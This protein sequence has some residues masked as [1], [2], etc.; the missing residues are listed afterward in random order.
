MLPQDQRAPLKRCAAPDQALASPNCPPLTHP[1]PSFAPH[2][3]GAL[4]QLTMAQ[5]KPK[6]GKTRYRRTDE[7]LIADLQKRIEELKQRKAAKK[8]KADPAAKEMNAAFRA[9]TKA[10]ENS[11]KS[12]DAELKRALSGAQRILA[13]YYESKGISVPKARKPRARRKK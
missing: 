11:K 2:D 1:S 3:T 6:A 5:R 12:S 9:L 7:E 13:E 8:V 10:V 4:H